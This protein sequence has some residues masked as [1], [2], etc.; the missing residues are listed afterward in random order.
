MVLARE[1]G[2]RW[3]R[4]WGCERRRVLGIVAVV[5]GRMWMKDR[6]IDGS[7]HMMRWISI[8]DTGICYDGQWSE[9]SA[10]TNGIR[11]YM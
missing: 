9:V 7:S 8:V 10:L 11:G 5:V 1:L 4:F 6:N 2:D 3:V